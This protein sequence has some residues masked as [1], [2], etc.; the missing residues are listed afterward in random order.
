VALE[1]VREVVG[2]GQVAADGTRVQHLCLGDRAM[3]DPPL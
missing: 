2:A 1:A 3:G